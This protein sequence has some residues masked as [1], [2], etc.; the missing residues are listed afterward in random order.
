[1]TRPYVVASTTLTMDGRVVDYGMPEV[2]AC[3]PEDRNGEA[4][5]KREGADMLLSGADTMWPM[6]WLPG[7]PAREPWSEPSSG[8]APVRHGPHWVAIT[9]S[10]GRL[11]KEFFDFMLADDGR[12]AWPG[13][14]TR[15]PQ[16]A[17]LVILVSNA[18]PDD[19]CGYL[20]DRRVH[21][22]RVGHD[23]VDLAAALDIVAPDLGVSRV[24]ADSGAA[25]HHGL[26]RANVV[27]EIDACIVPFVSGTP[28]PTVFQ[29]DHDSGNLVRLRTLQS[30]QH[31]SGALTVRYQVVPV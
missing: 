12:P 17:D 18:S 5:A 19:Y 3:L 2:F 14:P 1:M 23:K 24:L 20:A 8:H 11:P 7:T 13:G 28:G 10:R 16:A 6:S 22:I 9:D 27:D 15:E 30:H 26:L 21:F 29:H 25:L 31:A 4:M